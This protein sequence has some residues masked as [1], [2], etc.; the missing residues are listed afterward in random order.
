MEIDFDDLK[1][2]L[3]V[4]DDPVFIFAIRVEDT[5]CLSYFNELKTLNEFQ[6][7]FVFSS[8][9]IYYL[10]IFLDK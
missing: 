2:C 5:S 8:H 4:F 1:F 3:I 9:G 6:K 7:D 10:F